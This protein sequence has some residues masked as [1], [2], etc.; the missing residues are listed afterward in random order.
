MPIRISLVFPLSQERGLTAEALAAWTNQTLP[1]ERYE[2]IV[3]ADDRIALD[4]AIS[5][6]LR[7]RPCPPRK[8]RESRAPIRRRNARGNR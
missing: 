2:I 5:T 7:A 1:G 3:V 8:V 6:L 4:P